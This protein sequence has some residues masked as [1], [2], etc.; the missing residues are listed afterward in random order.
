MGEDVQSLAKRRGFIWQSAEIYGALAGFYDYGA[1]GATLKR[2]WEDVWLDF[3]LDLNDN[4][5]LIDSTTILPEA[6]LKASGH[7]DSFTDPLVECNKCGSAFRADQLI[8][9]ET[10]ESAEGLSLEEMDGKLT[11]LGLRCLKCKGGFDSARTFNM[12]FP[13]QVGT[14]GGDVAY[15]R[16]ETAQGA[17]LNFKRHFEIMRRKLPLGLAIIGKAYRNEIAPRQGVYRMRELIQAE[18]QIFMDPETFG[19]QLELDEMKGKEIMVQ[20]VGSRGRSNAEPVLCEILIDAHGLPPFFVYHMYKIQEFYLEEVGIPGDK[21]RFFEKSEKERAFYNLLHFDIEVE[22]ST[23]GGFRELAGIHYRGDYDLSRHQKHSKEKMEVSVDGKRLVP[24]VLELSFG[25]DRNVWALLDIHFSDERTGI[26]RLPPRLAPYTFAVFPLMKKDDLVSIAKELHYMLKCRF[27][28]LY[29]ASGS[30]GKRYARMDEIG[31]PFC[32][33]VDY[34]GLED[35]TVTVRD[36]DSTDQKR[37]KKDDLDRI[38][39]GLASGTISF[40]DL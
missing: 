3:F 19:A 7:L 6:S 27:S 15:L 21:F 36:R 9:N 39:F 35:G 24:H 5:H 30:I 34:D 32:V 23:L 40:K 25:V 20:L 38:A 31:T 17:Y 4:Y 28:T 16:P 11:E 8:E 37:V 22:L 2:R 29:D 10:G 33:T 1:M 13:V 26:L 18:L 12:M 14:K